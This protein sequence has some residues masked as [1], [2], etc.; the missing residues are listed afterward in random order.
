MAEEGNEDGTEDRYEPECDPLLQFLAETS[1]LAGVS[2]EVTLLTNGMS[3]SGRLIGELT[4]VQR[5]ADYLQRQQEAQP[6]RALER[7]D[8]A[9]MMRD[10][11]RGFEPD[12]VLESDYIHLVDATISRG[13]GDVAHVGLWRGAA[14]NIAGWSVG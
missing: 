3:V 10:Q 9:A 14:E 4:Y 11:I 1:A 6:E 8:L 5:L 2:I 12:A 7:H 13:V